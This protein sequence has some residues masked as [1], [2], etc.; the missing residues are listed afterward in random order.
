VRTGLQEN[1]SELNREKKPDAFIRYGDN[2]RQVI[3][4]LLKKSA[5]SGFGARE[6][7]EVLG[8]LSIAEDISFVQPKVQAGRFSGT[9]FDVRLSLEY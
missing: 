1:G 9:K 4:L 5:N 8:L 6:T 3:D 7:I 2:S